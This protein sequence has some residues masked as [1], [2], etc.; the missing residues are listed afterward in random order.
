MSNNFIYLQLIKKVKGGFVKKIIKGVIILIFIS[1]YNSADAQYCTPPNSNCELIDIIANVKVTTLTDSI[2]INNASDC[3]INGFSDY[4]IDNSVDTIR[5]NTN[6]SYRVNVFV[7]NGGLENVGFWVDF[8]HD[9]IFESSEYTS[10]GTGSLINLTGVLHVPDTA[11][12]GIT[13]IRFRVKCTGIINASDACTFIQ[14][15]ETE[16]YLVNIQD[17]FLCAVIPAA[18]QSISSRDT[19]CPNVSFDL[20]S[21]NNV[22]FSN[23]LNYRWQQSLDNLVYADIL[24]ADSSRLTISATSTS[25]YRLIISCTANRDTSIPVKVFV[26]NQSI[27]HCIPTTSNCSSGNAIL[28]VLIDSIDNASSCSI[29]GY[30][31][32]TLDSRIRPANLHSGDSI[33]ISITVGGGGDGYVGCW[34]DYNR[35][36]IFENSEYDSIGSGNGVILNG[37]IRVPINMLPGLAKMRISVWSNVIID[38]NAACIP[39]INGETEDY[40]VNIISCTPVQILQQPY[41]NRLGCGDSAIFMVTTYG[42]Y[43]SCQW[44]MKTIGSPNWINISD[45]SNYNGATTSRLFMN[46]ITDSMNEKQYRLLIETCDSIIYSDSATLIV[47]RFITTVQPTRSSICEGHAVLLSVTGYNAKWSPTNGLYINSGL[48]IPYIGT[49]QQDLYAS[50]SLSTNYSVVAENQGC[51][52]DSAFVYIE[53]NKN[54]I[55]KINATPYLFLFPG[56]HTTLNSSVLYSSSPTLLYQWKLD[57]LNILG[58]TQSTKVVDVFSLGKYSLIVTDSNSCTSATSNV[59]VISDSFNTSLF[60]YPNPSNG[61]F[62]ISYNNKYSGVSNP[63]TINIYDAKG[64]K[65]YK[66]IYQINIPFGNME[67]DLKGKAKG[68]YFIELTDAAERRLGSGKLLLL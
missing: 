33:P 48:T 20:S 57:G 12:L 14:F 52:S 31:D 29:N 58:A 11:L 6:Q 17:P 63:R 49:L 24:N 62:Q 42:Y 51:Q 66:K 55:I 32:Y 2:L 15:G 37:A 23:R 5:V 67:V 45:G 19:V 54:P 13:R 4:T 28:H 30:T 65:V 43:Q 46:R 36:G 40:L 3:G 38:S 39:Y 9:E 60:I 21:S 34:I 1:A 27:C 16:D 7:G 35:N 22:H 56:I 8:N 68:L 41:N 61:I 18:G 64:L 50:P 47:E 25:W 53:V 26:Q 10:L 59:I 44:Q